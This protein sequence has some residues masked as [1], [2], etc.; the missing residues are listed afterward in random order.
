MKKSKFLT[1]LIAVALLLCMATVMF[2]ACDPDDPQHVDPPAHEHTFEEKWSHND[3]YHWH[4]ATCDHKDEVSQME[5]HTMVWTPVKEPTYEAAGEDEGECNVCHYKTTRT[6]PQ[7]VLS[8]ED[9]QSEKLFTFNLLSDG[10]E[11]VKY[12]GE[13]VEVV[14]PSTYRGKDVIR[15]G[16]KAFENCPDLETLVIP[17]SIKEYAEDAFD[18]CHSIKTLTMP[19]N[20]SSYI[21]YD[22]LETV[23]I[24][25]GD[26][27]G[28]LGS[29][30]KLRTV[31]IGEDVTLLKYGTFFNCPMLETVYWNAIDC[32]TYNC[33]KTYSIFK[34]SDNIKKVVF[35]DSV[36]SIPE[37][38]FSGM[39]ELANFENT[40]NIEHIGPWAFYNTAFA[41]A[42]PN[43]VNYIGKVLYNFVGQASDNMH[44]DVKSGT[45]MICDRAFLSC[46]GLGSIT[47]A[48]SVKEI[49]EY[50]FYQC[51]G[52]KE[53]NIPNGVESL[54]DYAFY[55]CT[56]V[57]SFTIGDDVSDFGTGVFSKTD[58]E[59]QLPSGVIYLGKVLYK[60][61]DKAPSDGHVKIKD[62]T[63]QIA[64]GAFYKCEWLT[65]VDIPESVNKIGNSAF[66]VT[67]LS[68]I[69]IPDN[70]T[71][72]GQQ[73]FYGAKFTDLTIPE[74]VTYIGP[75]AFYGCTQLKT[76]TWNAKDAV[77][78]GSASYPAFY[79]CTALETIV[80]GDDVDR[81]EANTF[82]YC[83]GLK[84]VTV[85]TG[86]K[87]LGLETFKNCEAL[88][89]INFNAT[90]C[91]NVGPTWL[92]GCS[93]IKNVILA[94]DVKTIPQHLLRNLT[95]VTSF[96]I[97]E[98]VTSIGMSA[99]YGSGLTTIE[100]PASVVDMGIRT[101]SGCASLKSVKLNA[102]ATV[103]PEYMFENCAQ[104]ES[105]VISEGVKTISGSVFRSC[106]QLRWVCLPLSLE[107]IEGRA[108]QD[109]DS[110][111]AVYY[112]GSAEQWKD[113][114]VTGYANSS[115]SEAALYYFSD[116]KNGDGNHWHWNSQHQPELW[117]KEN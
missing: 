31:T 57:E 11:I 43:G 110:L 108:F 33:S 55:E 5:K 46:A 111:E 6:V 114:S 29:S 12:I 13:S 105:I 101:F 102:A 86:V 85:G 83:T 95:G 38:A 49:G 73:A 3:E 115:F 80:I 50:A 93:A 77:T 19:G 79:G 9:K 109:C 37:Y 17:D 41:A 75:S 51:T 27:N 92:S 42:L 52:L 74:K 94:N 96:V 2:A 97:P 22:A 18:Q 23:T 59:S 1:T 72:I 58:F 26:V 113:V 4:A 81:V 35:G 8:E 16:E 69:K 116:Q 32:K 65:S 67:S 76:V 104:L 112:A 25:S 62:G 54:G 88:T 63:T 61:N 70:V 10:Y 48:D 117:A 56:G 91:P 98:G 87:Y 106:S 40:D 90:D 36:K 28:S 14:I 45:T 20:A 60:Y 39:T 82:A 99:F 34:D 89:T 103:L 7:L 100:I 30:K 66:S 64:D 68:E 24:T 53:I 21:W 71:F 15:I 107:T 47:I 44:V 84:T 78:V